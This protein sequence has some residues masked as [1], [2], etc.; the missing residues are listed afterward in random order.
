MLVVNFSLNML[1][2]NSPADV[3]NGQLRFMPGAFMY[4]KTLFHLLEVGLNILLYFRE[5]LNSSERANYL[6]QSAKKKQKN[7]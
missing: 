6:L 1:H 3:V 4:Y 7:I 2:N 5:S